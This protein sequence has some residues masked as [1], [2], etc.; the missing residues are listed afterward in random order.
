MAVLGQIHP[1]LL[2]A[3]ALLV[4]GDAETIEIVEQQDRQSGAGRHPEPVQTEPARRDDQDDDPGH[5]EQPAESVAD[6]QDAIPGGRP[7]G[8]V[9]DRQVRAQLH[10]L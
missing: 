1:R 3:L 4:A 2:L 8:A 7:A 6:E 10:L 9:I 5:H